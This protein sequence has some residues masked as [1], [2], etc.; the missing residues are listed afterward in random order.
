M[1]VLLTYALS[2][3][4]KCVKLSLRHSELGMPRLPE[5]LKFETRPPPIGLVTPISF[6]LPIEYTFPCFY[7]L[8]STFYTDRWSYPLH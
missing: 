8:L 1:H 5:G 3:M 6:Y 7:K 4:T 2:E